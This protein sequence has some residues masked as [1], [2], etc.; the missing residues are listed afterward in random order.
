VTTSRRDFF[1]KVF[2]AGAAATVPSLLTPGKVEAKTVDK[3]TYGLTEE[4]GRYEHKNIMFCRALWDEEYIAHRATLVQREVSVEKEHDAMAL[5]ITGWHVHNYGAQMNAY[6]IP[7]Q[8]PLMR[9]DDPVITMDEVLAEAY[10]KL[11]SQPTDNP[12]IWDDK[13]APNCYKAEPEV[14]SRKIKNAAL[15]LG[16]VLAGNTDMFADS[17]KEPGGLRWEI[18][19]DGK[20][21][22]TGKVPLDYKED[23]MI[24]V[25]NGIARIIM[26]HGRIYMPEDNN[27]CPKKICSLMGSITKPGE[28]ITCL[29]N[30]LVIRIL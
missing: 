5:N 29:P 6:G 10:S 14:L 11:G 17:V 25:K 16:G 28:R 22:R 4:F 30:K 21:I 18:T 2:L 24:P 1:K 8:P 26:D 19:I 15:F 20:T 13:P 23:I 12:M 27:I 9:W 3:P 7:A